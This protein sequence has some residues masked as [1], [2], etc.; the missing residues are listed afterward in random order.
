MMSDERDDKYIPID[1]DLMEWD[2]WGR[3]EAMIERRRR[4]KQYNSKAA[5]LARHVEIRNR[6]LQ[7]E[8]ERAID[9]SMR[10]AVRK[11]WEK[12]GDNLPESSDRTFDKFFI[13]GDDDR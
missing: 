11:F 3:R 6:L 10:E 4:R 9:A 1:P 13:R 5:V 7:Q 2:A 12:Y 8:K